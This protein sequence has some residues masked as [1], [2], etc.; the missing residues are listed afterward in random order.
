[1]SGIE[2]GSLVVTLGQ[3]LL[4]DGSEIILPSLEAFKEKDLPFENRLEGN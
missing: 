1:M 2:D 4:M 3:E